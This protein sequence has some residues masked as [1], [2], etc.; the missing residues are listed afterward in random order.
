MH[1]VILAQKSPWLGKGLPHS[2]TLF[3][4]L[5]WGIRALEGEQRL[6]ALLEQFAAGS[7]PFVLSSVFPLL[8]G[9]GG[10]TLPLLPQPRG[11]PKRGSEHD[12]PQGQRDRAGAIEDRAVGKKVRKAEWV[13]PR[14]F[15]DLARGTLNASGIIEKAVFLKDWPEKP[16]SQPKPEYAC[17]DRAI[18]TAD[19]VERL[20][21][22]P[23]DG[24]VIWESV[25][26]ARNAIDRVSVETTAFFHEDGIV[27]GEG[28]RA[29]CLLEAS[30]PDV[31]RSVLAAFRW[32]GERGIGGGASV[33]YG[34]FDAAAF[35]DV[36]W[37]PD[38]PAGN[39]RVTLSLY[40]PSVEER[41]AFAAHPE[42]VAYEPAI[43]KGRLESAFVPIPQVWKRSV[44]YLAEGA[45]FPAIPGR[46]YY[47]MNPVVTDE[48]EGLPDSLRFEAQ[49]LGFAFTVGVKAA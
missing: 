30:E 47:G 31:A 12:E 38:D 17:A 2:D 21:T 18:L 7:P 40:H 26:N 11:A 35:E 24:V 25:S 23:K 15:G 20:A 4:G 5:C 16:G 45:R 22:K 29:Y 33:G 34:R 48:A 49:A 28:V 42:A 14:M 19:D 6:V 44:L 36:S 37:L 39:T 13:T 46:Q 41:A 9:K 10:E 43:R 1:M 8:Q 27:L 3:G 32:L